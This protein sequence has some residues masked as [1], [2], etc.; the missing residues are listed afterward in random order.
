MPDPRL[1]AWAQDLVTRY[2][3]G[4]ASQFIL[5]GNVDDRLLLPVAGF[6]RPAEP[7]RLGEPGN[8]VELG[9]LT[10]F[11]VKVLMP[12]FEVILT[13]DLAVGLRVERGGEVF[14]QWPRWKQDP[15][16]PRHP[17]EAVE[18]ISHYLRY[19]SN[20][21]RLNEARAST[22]TKSEPAKSAIR[23]IQVGIIIRGADLVAPAGQGP[24]SYDL[25]ALACQLRDWAADGMLTGATLATFLIAGNRNDLHPLV[26]NNPR[27]A[28]V[29]VP[30][31]AP[32]EIAA[33]LRLLAPRHAA[34][35]AGSD[36]D[37][38]AGMLAGSTLN[39]VES[40]LKIREHQRAALTTD[41]LV[42]LKKELVE[43][44]CQGLI[45]F[46]KPGRTLDDIHGQEAL[47]SWLRQDIALWAQGDT[48]AL[49]MGY[50]LCGPVG[51]GKTYLVECLAGAA[52]VP[53][54]KLKNFRDKWVGSTEGNLE[55]IFRLV[56][57]LG[58]SIVF[59]DEADQALGKREGGSNDGGIGG[60]IYAMMAEEMSNPHNR[61][62][63]LWVLA[64]SRPDL[65]EV[66]LKRPGR[67]DVKIP[68]FPTTTPEEGFALLRALC[69]RRS[70]II[71]QDAYADLK[72]LI[73]DLLTPGAAEAVAV[74]TY[75]QHRTAAAEPVAALK[76][77]LDGY[78]PP[79]APR[80]IEAQIR[81]A[82]DEATDIAFV[83]ERFRALRG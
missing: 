63:I 50:L 14:Q 27:A 6:A 73:P 17:R 68:I 55:K 12:R 70:L 9:T 36:L 31:P 5:T 38:A 34:A 40:L 15:A 20:L 18:V 58:R 65:I 60:R 46:I 16:L 56:H 67:I 49:P 76:I 45:D 33:A 8:G 71:P 37:Q 74:K 54:V 75:R 22:S 19:V 42:Q 77:S 52:G 26:A 81:L 79:V 72:P 66:D 32:A 13:Y 51:T 69:K 47:K 28:H 41:A 78:Q 57:A 53:V 62:R 80:I 64:S 29:P 2:E 7:A 82:V 39:A 35:L 24:S 10:D 59:I 61:G 3:S 25:S 83:P 48:Q 4:A 43:T 21:A 44:D 23:A 30:L 1:P 11:L